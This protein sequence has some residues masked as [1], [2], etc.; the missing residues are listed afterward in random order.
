MSLYK[1]LLLNRPKEIKDL[2]GSSHCKGGDD[3][4]PAAVKGLL[5]D[6]GKLSDI[7]R[8]FLPMK[9]VSIGRFH[10]HIVCGCRLLGILD[11]G[12]VF[13]SDVP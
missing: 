9:S 5:Q 2:L 11:Q 8:P 4:I 1:L 6:P 3:H 7:I 13:V 12:L 10:D